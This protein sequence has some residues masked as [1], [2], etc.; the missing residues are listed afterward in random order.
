MVQLKSIW[1]Q[2]EPG[3]EFCFNSCMVQLKY[4][5]CMCVCIPILGFNSC[6]VQLKWW[7]QLRHAWCS[8]GFNSCMVQL[9]FKDFRADVDKEVCFNSCMVQ[10]KF[11]SDCFIF[12]Y[13]L[14]LIPVWCN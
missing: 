2:S 3:A 11:Y 4:P 10:L 6:M 13:V 14:V 8:F 5:Q 12:Y 7:R 9:K 1:G